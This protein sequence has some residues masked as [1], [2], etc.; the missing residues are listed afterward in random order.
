M[1]TV[2]YI[3]TKISTG[4]TATVTVEIM[5]RQ[6][7]GMILECQLFFQ[8]CGEGS[9]EA[10]WRWETSGIQNRTQARTRART[11]LSHSDTIE[12]RLSIHLGLFTE[13]SYTVPSI[14]I[15][16]HLSRVGL[17]GRREAMSALKHLP[18]R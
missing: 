4:W 12:Q 1:C 3:R 9:P 6:N 8:F 13:E 10:V 16:V 5:N 2:N 7:W 15:S 14:N 17:G 11:Q 18:Q